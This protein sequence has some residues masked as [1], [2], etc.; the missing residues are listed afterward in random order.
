MTTAAAVVTV[1]AV[2][3][4]LALLNPG[5][6]LARVEL[7]DGAVWLTATQDHKLGRYNV[8]IDELNAGLVAE[9]GSFDVLQDA[10]DVVLVESG[11]VSVVD[12][13]SV[14]LTTQVTA[15]GV[16]PSLV[17]D[18]AVSMTAGV[19][20]L[21]DSEGGLHVRA[22][23]DL[24][25]MRPGEGEPDA[26]LG[27]GGRAVV[28]TDGVA[29]GVAPDGTVTEVAVSGNGARTSQDGSLGE[30][31]LDQ[32]TAVGDEP[33]G[34]RGSTVVTRH[35]S[36]D[37]TGTNLTLQQPGPASS[38]V[39]VSSDTALIE[40]PLDGGSP[41]EHPSSGSGKPA[42]PVQVGTCAHGA[43]ASVKGS[44][45]R[46]CDGAAPVELALQ[47][48]SV[49]DQL[50]FR[51]NRSQ[52]VLND[53]LRGR[54]WEPQEDTELRAL[55]WDDIEQ[56]KKDDEDP[57]KEESDVSSSELQAECSAESAPPLA[58]NDTF[59]VRPGRTTILPVL[60]NDSSSDCGILVVSEF[61]SEKVPAAF[62]SVRAIYG[63]RALQ[64]EVDGDAA[65]EVEFSYTIEDG[66]GTSAP[67][68]ATVKL[69]V[70]GDGE[71]S[72]PVQDR[73]G[74]LDVEQGG[75]ARY[76]ALAN[77]HD[78]DGDDMVLVGATTDASIG[79]VQ[80]R[81]DGTITFRADGGKLGRAKVTVLVSDGSSLDP[82]P[83][84]IEVDV[85]SAGSLPPLI[86]PVHAVTYV[87]QPVLLEPLKA[88][89]STG[90][91]PARLASVEEVTGATVTS[92]LQAGTFTFS[93]PRTGSYYVKFVVAAPPQQATGIARIDVRDWPEEAEPPV[94]VRDRAFLP[95]GG[96]V[97]IDPLANDS[98]PAGGLL[99]LQSVDTSDA[100]GLSVAILD[101][102]FVQ[103][104]S[105]RTLDRV[106]VL[107]YT[108]SNGSKNAT[109][110]IVVQ[111][112]PPASSTQPPVVEPV[113]ATVRTGGVVTIP[114]LDSAYDPD[115]DA[116]TLQR[117]LVEELGD[118]EGL[119]F[120]SGDVLRYQAPSKPVTARAVFAVEDSTGRVTAASVTVRVH[121]S[122][123]DTKA[124][125]QPRDLEARVF[126]GE[127]VRID[128]PLIGIDPD[129]DGVA[130]LG[131]ASGTTKGRVRAVGADW[132]E[133]EAY[134]DSTGTEEFEY[135]VEDWVGQR[136]VGTIR[137]GISPRP[138]DAAAVVARDDEVTIRPGERI[139]VR[140]LANDVDNSGDEL[141]LAGI[142]PGE[143]VDAVI[144]GRRVV[145]TA[146]DEETVL[147]ILYTVT[148]SRG[149]QDT[150]VLTVKVTADAP[151]LPPI[152]EDVV[153][154]ATETFGLTEVVVD[155]LATAQNPSGPESD[156][157][158]R[159]P[160]SVAS[161]A[162]V[163]A[164]RKVLVT[165]SDQ[166]QT[167]PFELVNVRDPE[168]ANAYAFIT[169]P[170]L[171]FIRPSLRPGAPALR[172]ASGETLTIELEEQIKVAQGRRPSVAD[173][174]QVSATRGTVKIAKDGRSVTFTPTDDYSGPASVTMPVT[175]ATSA[176]DTS[177]RTAYLT[178]PIE[179]FAVDD[180]PP[181]FLASVVEVAP[182][183]P[184]KTVDLRAFTQ[185]PEGTE[186]AEGR[187]TYAI[188]G[189]VP[190][191]FKATLDE[192]R[193]SVEADFATDKG[194]RGLLQL[195]IGYGR[196]GK[197]DA[198]VDLRA[199]A[200]TRPKAKV[201]DWTVDKA[202]EGRPETLDVL[203]GAFNPFAPEPLRV[204]GAT[205][206]SGQGT[207]SA[208]SSR[209]TVTPAEGFIGTLVVRY[210]VRDVIDE[211][212][213]EVDGRVTLK[214]RGVPE[215]PTPPKVQ[216]SG[217]RTVLLSWAAP[218]NRGAPIT[219]YRL[220]TQDGRTWPCK[221]TT[222]TFEGLTNAQKYTFTVAAMNEVGWSEE[223]AP[224]G[225]A[226][227]DAKPEAPD[228]VN[229]EGFG[230]ESL[231]WS[232]SAAETRGSKIRKYDI[233]ISPTPPNGKA[234][235]E[236]TTTSYSTDGLQNGTSYSI[237]VRAYNDLEEPS[238]WSASSATEIPAGKPDAPPE[239]TATRVDTDM[240]GQIVVRWR[241]PSNN[242]DKIKHYRLTISGGPN[243]RVEDQIT[244]TSFSFTNAKNGVSYTF[245]VQAVNKAGA[246]EAATAQALTYGLPGVPKMRTPSAPP[247]EGRV[248]LSWDAA[249]DNGS[250]VRYEVR[251][252]SGAEVAVG[253]ATS[254]S[255][256]GLKG[257]VSHSYQ[258]RAVNAAGA[259]AWSDPV[260]ATPTTTA[261][262]PTGGDA[263]ITARESYGKPTELTVSW[264]P[265]SD[266]GSDAKVRYKWAVWTAEN[267]AE[268]SNATESRSI[269]VDISRWDWPPG[270]QRTVT[271]RVTAVTELEGRPRDGGVMTQQWTFDGWGNRPSEVT[272]ITVTPDSATDPG[273]FAVA[274]TAPSDGGVAI[275]KYEIGFRV[276]EGGSF[277]GW[278]SVG[279]ALEAT[280][281]A[282]EVV[283]GRRPG[284]YTLIVTVRAVN[285]LG[286][287]PAGQG[288]ASF[289]ISDPDAEPSPDPDGGG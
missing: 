248:D 168:N 119:M 176:N 131:L 178:L 136:A 235:R 13:A 242:G 96:E 43:W 68:T 289:T 127:V 42:A 284:K 117:A 192:S 222:C 256:S 53:A 17:Q 112:V 93:A 125:P 286:D 66:R 101:H 211:A 255:F 282:S 236:S 246:G 182:G 230:D 213:R 217:D 273:S 46:L 50:V 153:V 75:Q 204:V 122:D 223:S 184:A 202:E 22:L 278:R 251:Q 20:S 10:A 191:G 207:A 232:W 111:P 51:V 159:I 28:G 63:G 238:A 161:V 281:D 60:A 266:A 174:L 135:A 190:A 130:L 41:I 115:G 257:G 163:T 74:S 70:H 183:D 226:I 9:Q 56:K 229:V 165:L 36:V 271:L 97:T 116:L 33:V 143:G 188:S 264:S 243:S 26:E 287:G 203:E 118:G 98:D 79:T 54:V 254:T 205:V 219:E 275:E 212:D 21:V 270:R 40:V 52:V 114:V 241:P 8:Q 129:G 206:E 147:Q 262:A 14:S 142:Q 234:V 237:R 133:Y 87:D 34:L 2:V 244:D 258:V 49:E 137:V 185:T 231:T 123:P 25:S 106:V 76:D 59:G 55:N 73:R 263:T 274:W 225:Q 261:S 3:A 107:P 152:A 72:A 272:S 12:P 6:P 69:E 39:L 99:V 84:E 90:A 92:D 67:S 279:K 65:G 180:H 245:A 139:E 94:A 233:E 38:R 283:G 134:A 150:A 71:N 158:I 103:I 253:S 47:D 288:T 172:V 29:Y 171:G 35:G 1:P 7:N 260:S 64:V 141:T 89:R 91:E 187:Y 186:P 105:E 160:A 276:Q 252:D 27:R 208:T 86:D 132:I 157:D 30:G 220:T 166:T 11:R 164:D 200:S 194:T 167:L 218:D 199:I 196:A 209:V 224:S 173:P 227:P 148:N 215:R 210:R 285:A 240:G 61:E 24:D 277:S 95:A 259:G 195:T 100:D 126:A 102:H 15:P 109:G 269:P 149:G 146:P 83:G 198:Q 162:K 5:F 32:L 265:P 113:E 18:S 57:E 193:L 151:V 48:M 177:A 62:G 82:T 104:R 23:G 85:R 280:I 179:V 77:F 110:Q 88:V 156:L 169:V 128:V 45:Q 267:S 4:V 181:T 124:P 197:L 170:P 154:P 120:V 189:A 216:E 268:S 138:S 214:V 31:E 239:V 155:V 37:L 78:P 140:V 80:F 121:E 144:N 175:D 228:R 16:Q 249:D 201:L 44:Y 250:E 247:F 19:L 108:I 81:Q 221:S 58:K 145:V